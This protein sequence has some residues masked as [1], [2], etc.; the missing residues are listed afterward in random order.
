[1]YDIIH[2]SNHLEV[3]IQRGDCVPQITE[4]WKLYA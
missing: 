3:Q 4:D 2:I 1:M